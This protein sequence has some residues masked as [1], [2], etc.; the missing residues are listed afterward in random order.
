[1]GGREGL[2]FKWYEDG[3]KE[4]ESFYQGSNERWTYW[5]S[6]GKKR[7]EQNYRDSELHGTWIWWHDNNQKI[8]LGFYENGEPQGLWTYWYSD[9]TKWSEGFYQKGKKH[10]LWILWKEDGEKYRE[11]NFADGELIRERYSTDAYEKYFVEGKLARRIH[12][13]KNGKK[14]SEG[15]YTNGKREGLWTSWEPWS[16]IGIKDS[17]GNYSN[18]KRDGV[19]KEFSHIGPNS[20]ISTYVETI[21]ENGNLFEGFLRS[22]H[23]NGALKEEGNY[24][25]GKKNGDWET[26]GPDGN[27]LAQEKWSRGYL[28]SSFVALKDDNRSGVLTEWHHL[29]QKCAEG[30]FTNGKKSGRWTTW[31]IEGEELKG[32]SY[33]NGLKV[34]FWQEAKPLF[35]SSKYSEVNYLDQ[36]I[37]A[38]NAQKDWPWEGIRDGRYIEWGFNDKIARESNYSMG[39]PVGYDIHFKRNGTKHFE[40]FYNELGI[41]QRETSWDELGRKYVDKITTGVGEKLQVYYYPNGQ[42]SAEVQYKNRQPN[43]LRIKWYKNGQKKEEGNLLGFNKVG[44]WKYWDKN[45]TLI[46]EIDSWGPLMDFP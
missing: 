7:T 18:G 6:S 5:D 26:W 10:G 11:Q 32:G 19:W 25:Q 17:E 33:F 14:S 35:P 36:N 22:W 38:G 46:K 2:W 27:K 8:E 39:V 45:G 13:F 44:I 3:K 15:N 41:L 21:W 37:T 12:Y 4:S 42:K 30:N 9:G 16:P 34:G 23:E 29:G 1:M 31:T 28:V 40:C 24:T 20:S 43:G